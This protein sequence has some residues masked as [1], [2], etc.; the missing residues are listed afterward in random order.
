M[1][2]LFRAT[3]TSR[4]SVLI[5]LTVRAVRGGLWI[6]GSIR[7]SGLL[8][9]RAT[10]RLAAIGTRWVP[11]T[12]VVW[13]PSIDNADFA[14]WVAHTSDS[15]EK[16]IQAWVVQ[17]PSDRRRRRFNLLLL[18]ERH[19][20]VAFAKFT[21]NPLNPIGLE[22]MARFARQ[23]AETFWAPQLVTYGQLSGHSFVVTSPM[24]NRP[25]LP[26]L[27]D[28]EGRRRILSEIQI[29]LADLASPE[30][31]VHGDFAPWNVRRL[32]GGS[33]AVVDWEEATRGEV[34]AD[35][36]W[37]LVTVNAARRGNSA[38][39]LKGILTESRYTRVEVSA[40]AEFWLRRLDRPE[41]DEVD[42][43]LSL[44]TK[45]EAYARRIR[46]LLASVV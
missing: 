26:A 17:L 8:A 41:A 28:A 7:A 14:D 4:G 31:L 42:Q 11:G 3:W 32:R 22:A 37:Y 45:A 23:P 9:N 19:T 24:P 18:D 1:S 36:L 34:A 13:T 25:H 43:E 39:I 38:R 33:V 2:T 29:R 30:T 16:Q 15:L 46:S 20:P 44:A 10:G 6:Y 12:K 21:S 5:P 40:A 35:E 27:L